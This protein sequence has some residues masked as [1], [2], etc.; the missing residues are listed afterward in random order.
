MI[1]SLKLQIIL[2]SETEKSES[3]PNNSNEP[4]KDP[5]INDAAKNEKDKN[6]LNYFW[7]RIALGIGAGIATTFI[8]EEY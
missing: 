2:T 6:Y 8:F 4:S 1:L 3:I 5:P 7:M